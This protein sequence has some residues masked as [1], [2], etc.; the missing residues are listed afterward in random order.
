LSALRNFPDAQS[1]N[2]TTHGFAVLIL[3]ELTLQVKFKVHKFSRTERNDNLPLVRCCAN[4]SLA[5]RDPPLVHPP[6]GQDVSDA[7][8]VDLQESIGADLL[9]SQRR[10]R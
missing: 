1:Q 10:G 6:A 4:D 2:R 8:G 3:I 7:M 9:H 5:L